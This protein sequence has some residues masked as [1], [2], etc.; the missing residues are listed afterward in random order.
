MAL[1]DHLGKN[2]VGGADLTKY[3]PDDIDSMDNSRLARLVYGLSYV[4]LLELLSRPTRNFSQTMEVGKLGMA[5]I[6]HVETNDRDVLKLDARSTYDRNLDEAIATVS[7]DVMRIAA[8]YKVK[9]QA[10]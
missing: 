3:E 10:K 2:D 8:T 7:A 5:F 1:A 9:T 4:R 6:R